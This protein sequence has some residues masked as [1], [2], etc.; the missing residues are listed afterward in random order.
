MV[1]WAHDQEL[2]KN[3]PPAPRAPSARARRAI[4]G[5]RGFQQV[6]L[7]MGIVVA[8][9]SLIFGVIFCWHIPGDIAISLSPQK[10]RGTVVRAEHAQ[11]IRVNGRH[12]LK[13]S[14]TY[15]AD[16]ETFEG[17]SYTLDH[18][19][20]AKAL[21]GAAID[22]EVASSMPSVARAQGTTRSP[23]GIWTFPV[24][25]APL[26][27]L[28]LVFIAVRSNRR[29]IHAF[30]HGTATAG[31]VTFAGEDRSTKINGRHPIKVQWEFDVDGKKYTGKIS[32]TDRSD[33]RG[34]MT[35]MR[36]P[37]LYEP[38]N[39]AINTLYIE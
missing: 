11:H 29:E 39:P 17:E 26:V 8:A 28:L 12:P 23:F 1:E 6:L 4:F 24:L 21:P 16:G 14:F 37:I 33:F 13:I 19:Y 35:G 3:I 18:T 30:T 2:L 15:A 38:S 34:V 7:I 27:G 22:V 20:V 32:S 9:S 5:Y 25:F 36:V 10:A 31:H